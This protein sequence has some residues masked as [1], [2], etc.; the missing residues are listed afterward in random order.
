ML[1]SETEEIHMKEGYWFRSSL[2]QIEPGE[3][4]EV[5]PGIYGKQLAFWLK[6]KLETHGQPVLDVTPE[7]FGWCVRCQTRPFLLWVGCGNAAALEP[8]HSSTENITWHCFPVAETPLISHLFKRHDTESAL[9]R[10]DGLLQQIL[11]TETEIALIA[12]P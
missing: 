7:D 11:E 4:V 1:H 8:A 10:L 6:R 2:F 9:S 3:D 12:R 5:N